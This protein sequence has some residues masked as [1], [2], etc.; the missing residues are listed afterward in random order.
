MVK[1]DTLDTQLLEI[2]CRQKCKFYKA[3]QEI[4]EKEYQ[5][6]AYKILKAMLEKRKITLEEL[7]TFASLVK[8]DIAPSS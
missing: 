8:I 1:L 2:L 4:R 5:C 3:G 6:G 7:K